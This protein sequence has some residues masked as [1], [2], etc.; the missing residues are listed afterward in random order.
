MA[1]LAYNV[2]AL[3]QTA[4]RIR[5]ERALDE[6]QMELSSYYIATEI[7][8]NYAGMLIAVS[9]SVWRRYESLSANALAKLLLAISAKVDPRQFR[10]YPRGPKVVKKKGYVSKQAVQKHVATARVLAAGRIPT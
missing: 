4:V 3:L 5:H 8:A 1:L 6:A 9:A 2:L 7:K 10:S